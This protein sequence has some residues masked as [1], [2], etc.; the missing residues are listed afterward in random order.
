LR[1]LKTFLVMPSMQGSSTC[2]GEDDPSQTNEVKIALEHFLLISL[3]DVLILTI[4]SD[5]IYTNL[6]IRSVLIMID[7]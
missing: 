3:Y 1:V 6:L 7:S 5:S 2:I 4:E